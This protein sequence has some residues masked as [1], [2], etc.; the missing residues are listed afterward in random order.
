MTKRQR[1]FIGAALALAATLLTLAAHQLLF[2]PPAPV[3]R[4]YALTGLVLKN[5][6]W[7]VAG[8]LMA[9]GA[10][11]G[12]ALRTSP[13]AA[14]VGFLVVLAAATCYEIERYPTSHNLLPFDLISW[15]VMASPLMLGALLGARLRRRASDT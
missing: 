6:S 1:D 9:V 2:H 10:A 7:G 12:Y 8:V 3:S 14:G 13:L 4:E 5:Y 11:V 15:L